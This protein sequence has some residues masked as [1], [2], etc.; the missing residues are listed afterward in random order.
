M[1]RHIYVYDRKT[2]KRADTGLESQNLEKI[3]AF[4]ADR[5][6]GKTTD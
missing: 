1:H 4:Y 5:L 3:L 2:G 6:S